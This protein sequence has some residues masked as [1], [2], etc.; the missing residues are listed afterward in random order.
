MYIRQAS[1]DDVNLLA[2][3]GRRTF[4]DAFATHNHAADME[5]YLAEAFS[6]Q[7]IYSELLALESI[8]LLAYD[9]PHPDNQLVGYAR[10]LGSSSEPC[11]TGRYPVELVRLYVENNATSRGYG[12]KL[13]QACLDRA[14]QEGFETIWLG[15]WEKN[16]RAQQFYSRWRFRPIGTHDFFLGQQMQTDLILMRSVG[17]EARLFS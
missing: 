14:A 10:L 16:Y 6:P 3:L 8:F 5:A 9:T 4:F 15:V 7:R 13:M 17:G 1:C 11:V 12:S 2:N